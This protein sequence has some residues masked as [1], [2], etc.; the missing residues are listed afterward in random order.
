MGLY[1]R[2]L[3]KR[4]WMLTL[5]RPNKR[6]G[7][8][9]WVHSFLEKEVAT[10]GYSIVFMMEEVRQYH[11]SFLG[12][13]LDLML[14]PHAVAFSRRYSTSSFILPSGRV[15]IPNA[16]FAV[17]AGCRGRTSW[18]P[19]ESFRRVMSPGREVGDL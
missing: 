19:V 7:A 16:F 4:R 5:C 17:E 12:M 6:M 11:A 1:T 2:T 14:D 3:G 9:K 15:K 13:L 10:R 8:M 18:R